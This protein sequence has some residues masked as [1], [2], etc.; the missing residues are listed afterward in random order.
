LGR[1]KFAA[2]DVAKALACQRDSEPLYRVDP[3]RGSD[4]AKPTPGV[5]PPVVL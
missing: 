5:A 4:D 1:A 3:R 2:N